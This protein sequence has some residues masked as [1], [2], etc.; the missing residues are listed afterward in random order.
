MSSYLRLH[1]ENNDGEK[2][3]CKSKYANDQ[4]DDASDP[5]L[6]LLVELEELENRLVTLFLAA[7]VDEP[8]AL[9]H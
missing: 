8:I 3:S 9:H 7:V 4:D 1:S 5:K 2:V 6:V